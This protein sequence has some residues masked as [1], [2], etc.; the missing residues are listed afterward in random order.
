[1]V[2]VHD[3][4]NGSVQVGTELRHQILVLAEMRNIRTQR[5]ES[6]GVHGPKTA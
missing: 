2:A 3:V 1:M 5:L 6:I 4:M